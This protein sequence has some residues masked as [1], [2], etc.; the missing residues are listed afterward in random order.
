MQPSRCLVV[1]DNLHT[2][3]LF[4]SNCGLKTLLVLTGISSLAE[5]RRYQASNS[6]HDQ[7]LVPDFYLPSIKE[8]GQ[9]ITDA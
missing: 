4:G 2:D 1:G 6:V 7:K 9:L 5:A 8:L 3:I